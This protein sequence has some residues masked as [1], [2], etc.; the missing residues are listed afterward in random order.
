[1]KWFTL[2][3]LLLFS[4]S[5]AQLSPGKLHSVHKDLE[6]IENCLKCH[7]R[8]KGEIA[9]EKCLA[10]HKILNERIQAGK[11]FH[12]Q[13]DM[14]KCGKCHV[15]HV[16]RDAQ[17]IFWK[18]GKEKF[19]HSKT[20]YILKG[21]HQ[22][23]KCEKC[24]N[25]KFIKNQ[26]KLLKQ[27]KNLNRTFLGLRTNCI[28]CH[29]D[30]HRNQLGQKCEA[31]HNE[32]KNWKDA[33]LFDHK[34]AGFRLTG[35]HQSVKCEKC[36]KLTKDPKSK[37]DPD[38][39]WMKP[40]KHK[41]CTDCHK[42]VHRG[43]FGGN[44]T[45]C[46]T[47]SGW[48]AIKG[49]RFNHSRTQFPLK[50]KHQQ[51]RCEKCHG[52]GNKQLHP[53]FQFC[54]NCHKDYHLGQ[55]KNRSGIQDCNQCHT[56]NGFSPSIYTL[57]Q[58]QKSKYPLEG[59]HQAIPCILCHKEARIRGKQTRIFR[60]TSTECVTCHENVHRKQLNKWM[61]ANKCESC[62]NVSG[63]DQ[64]TTFDHSKTE[65]PL[66]GKHQKV[67]CKKCHQSD[68]QVLWGPIQFKNGK[69]ECNN[70]HNDYHAGQFSQ[71]GNGTKCE[72][73]HQESGWEKLLFD[74]NRD[75]RFK[76][77]GKHIKVRCVQCHPMA[78]INHE[79]TRLFKPMGTE[80]KDC[81]GNNKTQ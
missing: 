52:Q 77:K 24:H 56:E 72:K 47:T 60:F 76:L 20:G 75:S 29:R 18:D 80:C 27:K 62:H 39:L 66:K 2:I 71:A 74:H 65:F 37:D 11:G 32:V 3:F 7:T 81:H 73:C 4:S 14:K 67:R 58:H 68:N 38:F 63:W 12:S 51:V 16:G 34:K 33:P 25:P 48:S 17:L 42:D 46:H 45:S 50:G 19:D 1:M 78:T 9:S 53:K 10:C 28:D 54:Y 6:G 70:C 44:C 64:I 69:K 30:E 43:K 79:R 8:Q 23:I 21:K 31:C 35:K 15:E 26:K 61:K 5:Y 40:I 49:N 57:T 22:K 59:A 13:E 55:F 41:I 36:H